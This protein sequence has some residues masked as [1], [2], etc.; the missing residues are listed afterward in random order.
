MPF[1]P[2]LAPINGSLTLSALVALLPLLTVLIGLGVLRWKAHL[3]GLAAVT[4]AILIATLG[5][6]MPLGLALAGASQGLG[7]A[8]FPC[9]WIVLAAIWMFELTRESGHF[10]DLRATFHVISADPR[11]LA[12]LIAFCFG[13]LLEALAGFGAP[14]AITGVMLLSI[15]YP[16]MRAAV[17]VLIANTA[18]VAFG[19]IGMPVILAGSLTQLPYTEIGAI[20]GTQ[21]AAIAWFIPLLLVLVVDGVRGLKEVWPAALGIGVAFAGAKF[22]SSNFISVELTDVIAS[23]AGIAAGVL[24]M[25]FWQPA[26][27]AEATQRLLAL[28]ETEAASGLTSTAKVA[29]TQAPKLTNARVFMALLPYLLVV[30]IFSMASLFPPLK[31]ALTSTDI[32]IQW[33]GLWD[34]GTARVLTAAGEP[35]MSTIFN[36]NWLSS[37]GTLM[38]FTGLLVAIIYRVPPK[39]AW[40][41]LTTQAWRLRMLVPTVGSVVALAYVMNLSGQTITIGMW[42]AGAGAAFAFL[43]PIL[44]WIGTAVTGSDTSS[45]ALFVTLQQTAAENIG[46]DPRLLVAGNT[47]GGAIAKLVSPQNLAVAATAV[48]LVGR[49]STILRKTVGWSAGLLAFMCLLVGLQSTPVLGWMVR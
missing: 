25:R 40:R 12:I 1:E 16:A 14:V 17:T 2:N 13:A 31:R 19:G 46:I 48:G 24:I 42:I 26:G 41:V 44:G 23:M 4:M 43:S 18:P 5:F 28:R 38:M 27:G 47:S 45:N 36:L 33:P 39:T 6:K 7:F 30:V 32:K 8:L 21:T 10:E 3:A 37:A 22:I 34:D 11:I 29:V 20:V 15:G 9:V 49:E 35:N